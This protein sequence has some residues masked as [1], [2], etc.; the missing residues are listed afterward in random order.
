VIAVGG[1]HVAQRWVLPGLHI[2]IGRVFSENESLD[3]VAV[4]VQQEDD[5]SKMVPK[6]RGQFLH[7]QLKRSI[8]Y[9]ENVTPLGGR[10]KGSEGR[11]QAVVAGRL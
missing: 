6:Y 4:V 9:K 5:R 2:V 1:E 7:G 10:Q 11:R 8:S 3:R